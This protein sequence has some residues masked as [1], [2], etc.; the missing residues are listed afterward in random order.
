MDFFSVFDIIKLGSFIIIELFYYVAKWENLTSKIGK[1]RKMKFGKIDPGMSNSNWFSG[2][3]FVF[4]QG[5]LTTGR[6][7]ENIE[8]NF[9]KLISILTIWI[10]LT[11]LDIFFY[12][13]ADIK[14]F[15][16]PP[17]TANGAASLTCA[18]YNI[19]T[20]EFGNISNIGSIFTVFATL[21]L[22]MSSLLGVISIFKVYMIRIW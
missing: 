17:K 13:I 18:I 21:S 2:C 4:E 1:W 14:G 7:F 11:N 5:K 6:I 15:K 9:F 16:N 10:P 22:K 8:F 12:F 19:R 20:V 3:K